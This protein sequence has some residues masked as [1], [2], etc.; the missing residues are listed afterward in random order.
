[1]IKF[2]KENKVFII[3]IILLFLLFNIKLPYYVEM[4]GGTININNRIESENQKIKYNGSYNMLYVSEKEASI[5]NYLLSYLIDD[6]DL[7]S[8]EEN[9]ISNETPEEILYRNKIML[10]NSINIA[11]YVAYKEAGKEI[12]ISSQKIVVIGKL[13]DNNLQIGDEVLSINGKEATSLEVIKKEIN[14]HNVNDKLQIKV[15]RNNK[16]LTEEVKIKEQQK[17]KVIGV[18]IVT[19]YQFKTNPEIKINFKPSE[20]GSSGGLMMTISMYNA[21]TN[22]DLLKGRNVAGTGT[23]SEDGTVGEIAGIKYKIIGA[24][25]NNIDTVLVP[26]AN[27]KEAMKIKKEKKYNDMEIV[28][29]ETFKDAIDYLKK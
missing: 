5:P 12:S 8:I 23:I 19:N 11:K 18:V 24:H 22:E 16:E 2:L 9:R 14:S 4:P 28:K 13:I 15:K 21:L 26:S 20:S 29:V 6:W 25:N 10:E 7:E 1:M 17:Q 27:Y 3:T